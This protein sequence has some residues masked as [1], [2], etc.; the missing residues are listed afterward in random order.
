MVVTASLQI[1]HVIRGKF[2]LTH[3]LLKLLVCLIVCLQCEQIDTNCT[4]YAQS[5]CMKSVIKPHVLL[6]SAQQGVKF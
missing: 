2:L 6:L 5:R 4:V 3:F 1:M